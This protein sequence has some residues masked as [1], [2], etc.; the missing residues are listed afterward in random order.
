V[1]IDQPNS[2][3][4]DVGVR[5]GFGWSREKNPS[6]AKP[7]RMVVNLERAK[8][9]V[10]ISVFL[11]GRERGET[12]KKAKREKRKTQKK[13]GEKRDGKG[14]RICAQESKIILRYTVDAKTK[15][16]KDPKSQIPKRPDEYKYS[17]SYKR[18]QDKDY[19]EQ[20]NVLGRE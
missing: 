10:L 11:K 9:F 3:K 8:M 15:K 6:I 1:A 16:R 13:K 19:S 17:V 7:M 14:D 20:H 5:P 4:T 12:E 18:Q 2:S